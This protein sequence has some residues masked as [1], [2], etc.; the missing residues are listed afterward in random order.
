MVPADPHKE[1]GISAAIGSGR[2]ELVAAVGDASGSLRRRRVAVSGL[3]GRRARRRAEPTRAARVS[4]AARQPAVRAHRHWPR[5]GRRALYR[6]V[7][8]DTVILILST[9]NNN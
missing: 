9:F 3:A 5:A 7:H 1:S 8:N 4:W 6:C 2:D